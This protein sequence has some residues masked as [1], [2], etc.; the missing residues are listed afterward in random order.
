MFSIL[1]L[2]HLSLKKIVFCDLVPCTCG[3]NRRFGG[4]CRLHLQGKL[5]DHPLSGIRDCL[6]NIVACIRQ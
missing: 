5:E 6:F 4:T 1:L 3:W 2:I